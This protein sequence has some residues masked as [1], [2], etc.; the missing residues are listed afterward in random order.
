MTRRKPLCTAAIALGA[1]LFGFTP[2][3]LDHIKS[4]KTVLTALLLTGISVGLLAA[5]GV[6]FLLVVRKRLINRFIH[7]NK[8]MGGILQDIENGLQAFSRYLGHA[9]N[10]MREFSVCNYRSR[11]IDMKRN[12]LKKHISDIQR[13]IDGIN[14]LFADC[15][16]LRRLGNDDIRPYNFDFSQPVDYVYDIPYEDTNSEVEFI[17]KDNRVLV[18]IDYVKSITLTREELYD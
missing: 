11:T 3:L 13:K 5:I 7:F 8:V 1:F 12:I 15:A 10:V 17:R 4:P 14:D 16:D 6:I 18:P 2:L 9:C